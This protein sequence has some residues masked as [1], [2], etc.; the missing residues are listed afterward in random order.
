MTAEH[1]NVEAVSELCP[2]LGAGHHKVHGRNEGAKLRHRIRPSMTGLGPTADENPVLTAV[3]NCE[4]SLTLPC[5]LEKRRKA[6]PG[7]SYARPSRSLF[8]EM[9]SLANVVINRGTHESEDA[10]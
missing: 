9:R 6:E 4:R 10:T 8:A 2:V 1:P 7:T 3:E 5:R